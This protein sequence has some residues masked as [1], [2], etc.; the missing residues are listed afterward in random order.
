MRLVPT[1]QATRLTGLSTAKL[2]E[3]TSRRALI[4]ADVP[5]RAQGSPAQYGWQTILLLRIAV[6]LRDRFHLELQAHREIFESLRTS[7]E[8]TSFVVLWGKVL[9]L[10]DEH[11][12]SLFDTDDQLGNAQ[13]ALLI[14]LDPHLEVLAAGFA[15]PN[16][17]HIPGQLNLFPTQ[18]VPDKRERETSLP[19]DGVAVTR[20]TEGQR[21]SA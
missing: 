14:R 21:R 16:P 20:Q 7:L 15:L 11:S 13:D 9:A 10:H 4:P 5:P 12:W 3:W 8:E 6:I 2:R 19:D 18:P 17:S 1:R